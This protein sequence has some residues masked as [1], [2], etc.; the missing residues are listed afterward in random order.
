MVAANVAMAQYLRESR[1]TVLRRVVRRR[2]DGMAFNHRREIGVKLPPTP[3]ARALSI[4]WLQR[5]SPTLA[6]FPD[7]RFLL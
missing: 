5:N 7:L 1:L 2:N 4:F 6:H 3:D